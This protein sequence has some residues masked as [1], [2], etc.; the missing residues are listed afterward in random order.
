MFMMPY[1]VACDTVMHCYAYN[2]SMAPK[3]FSVGAIKDDKG[4][5]QELVQADK[6]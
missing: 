5:Y 3:E 1:D 6:A 2:K 4:K